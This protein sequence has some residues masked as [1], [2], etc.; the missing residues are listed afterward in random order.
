MGKGR[1]ILGVGILGEPLMGPWSPGPC[2]VEKGGSGGRGML[3]LMLVRG[4]MSAAVA[5]VT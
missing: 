5:I 3:A 4:G 1:C 2:V